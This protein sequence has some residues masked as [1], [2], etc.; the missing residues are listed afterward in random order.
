MGSEKGETTDRSVPFESVRVG[1][2]DLPIRAWEAEVLVGAAGW[3]LIFRGAGFGLAAAL[4]AAALRRSGASATGPL[5]AVLIGFAQAT[6]GAG[7]L[8]RWRWAWAALPVE[9]LAWGLLLVALFVP[10]MYGPRSVLQLLRLD[11]VT[12]SLLPA[13]FLPDLFALYAAFR[14]DGRAAGKAGGPA[15]APF[16]SAWRLRATG[17]VL[18]ALGMAALA[19]L[20]MAASLL[21]GPGFLLA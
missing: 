3:V 10:R 14:V 18:V 6:I 5:A 12:L 7:L 19:F 2:R 4:G 1:G 11:P 20:S 9:V 15:L 13:F 16:W 8:R 17:K 21:L